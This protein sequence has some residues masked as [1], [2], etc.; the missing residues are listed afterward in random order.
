MDGLQHSLI[1]AVCLNSELKDDQN[2]LLTDL[3]GN[4]PVVQ[5]PKVVHRVVLLRRIRHLPAVFTRQHTLG[6]FVQ[7][8]GTQ[9]SDLCRLAEVGSDVVDFF[10]AFNE[11][12]LDFV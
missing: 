8:L 6:A 12:A 3:W 11:Y 10:P 1:E 5:I 9:L 7:G 4:A 2:C